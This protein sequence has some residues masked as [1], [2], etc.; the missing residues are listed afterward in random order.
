MAENQRYLFKYYYIGKEKFHGSQRQKDFTTI[1]GC[2]IDI[3]MKKKYIEDVKNSGIEFASRTD[4]LVSAKGAAFSFLTSKKP[5]LMEINS[6]L[7][8][9]IGLWAYTSVPIDY[10]SRYNAIMRH[11]KYIVPVPLSILSKNSNIDL[12][13]MEKACKELEGQHDY[14]N[15]SKWETEEARTIRV[16]DTVKMDVDDDFIIFD[17]KSKAYL[18]QQIR[19]MVKKILELGKGVISFDDFQKLFDSS[20]RISYQPADPSGLILWDI[21]FGKS[22]HFEI[23]LKSNERMEKYFFDQKFKFKFKHQLFNILQQHNLSQ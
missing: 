10:S 15:F 17:F 1:E 19:R 22:V 11:Y 7:P 14:I 21:E 4:R 6:D 12:K 23:D 3:L 2:L 16:I 5:I 18:R 13:L 20:Q 9:E 8:K